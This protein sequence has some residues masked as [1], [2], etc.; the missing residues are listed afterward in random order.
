MQ[1][2]PKC[3]YHFLTS[4]AITSQIAVSVQ[5]PAQAVG[6]HL[7]LAVRLSPPLQPIVTPNFQADFLC[8]SQVVIPSVT[9]LQ[10]FIFPWAQS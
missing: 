6:P 9:Q 5:K 3:S 4:R 2:K 10:I 1:I 8:L 7:I